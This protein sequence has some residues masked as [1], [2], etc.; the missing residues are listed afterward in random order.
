MFTKEELAVI[1]ELV[2]AETNWYECEEDATQENV[3]K[4][5]QE[6]IYNS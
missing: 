3:L 6:K 4:S 2:Q 5:I 1:L